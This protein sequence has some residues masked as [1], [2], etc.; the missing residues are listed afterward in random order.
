M[1]VV[2]FFYI[3]SF[4]TGEWDNVCVCNMYVTFVSC[5]SWRT[6]HSCWLATGSTRSAQRS[7]CL[8]LFPSMSTLSRSSFSCCR[9]LVPQTDKHRCH[10]CRP[11]SA[12]SIFN[13]INKEIN[14]RCTF[15]GFISGK[16][17][18]LLLLQQ[19]CVP[20]SIAWHPNWRQMVTVN[21]A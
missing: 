10:Y 15:M 2:F 3:F 14:I 1:K 9:S 12:W 20:K 6:I 18:L 16:Q 11:F 19:I 13:Q 4:S 7:M 5:S 8:L 17:K 21:F